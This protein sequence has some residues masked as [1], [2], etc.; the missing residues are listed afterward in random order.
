MHKHIVGTFTLS[1]VES[2]TFKFTG[3]NIQ[4]NQ[5][6]IFIDQIEYINSFKPIPCPRAGEPDQPLNKNQFKSYRG[7]TGQLSW[8]AEYTRLDL[9]FDVRELACRNK[10]ATIIDIKIAN[11]VLLKA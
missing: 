7:L 3:L 6:G 2:G 10:C 11:K 8:A 9:A 5:E 1:K 4:Q